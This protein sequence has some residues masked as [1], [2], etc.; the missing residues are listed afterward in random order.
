MKR[1]TRAIKCCLVVEHWRKISHVAPTWRKK[2][3]ESGRAVKILSIFCIL[4]VVILFFGD[5]M[6][7]QEVYNTLLCFTDGPTCP[8]LSIRGGIGNVLYAVY[9][10]EISIKLWLFKL[11]WGGEEGAQNGKQCLTHGSTRPAIRWTQT[12]PLCSV[13][14]VVIHWQGLCQWPL[15]FQ[16]IHNSTFNFQCSLVGA[17]VLLGTSTSLT[18]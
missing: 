5:W 16:W 10:N 8:P 6:I 12:R 18:P 4:V 15:T 17:K 11:S 13:K 9:V 3:R 14:K 7:F 1:G 2:E